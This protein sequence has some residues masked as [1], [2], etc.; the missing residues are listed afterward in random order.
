VRHFKGL[1][2]E[3]EGARPKARHCA[4]FSVLTMWAV[5]SVATGSTRYIA[6]R[7]RGGARRHQVRGARGAVRK[8]GKA[9][10][11]RLQVD[12]QQLDWQDRSARRSGQC[13]PL[14]G[15]QRGSCKRIEK[16]G[17]RHKLFACEMNRARA[18]N[19]DEV[20]AL[21][22]ATSKSQ[23]GARNQAMILF[24]HRTG[25]RAHHPKAT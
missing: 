15:R 3:M 16:E 8:T 7:E 4:V 22:R 11:V 23:H 5:A 6:Q 24:S 19:R 2:D 1:R 21:L 12:S 13:A 9:L 25:S 18:T 14:R 20:A 10:G 17:V